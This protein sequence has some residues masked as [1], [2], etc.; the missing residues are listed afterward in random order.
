MTDLIFSIWRNSK[1]WDCVDNFTQGQ[2]KTGT[3]QNTFK[4]TMGGKKILMIITPVILWSQ[5]LNGEGLCRCLGYSPALVP[6]SSWYQP[7][8]IWR[9]NPRSQSSNFKSIQ[10]LSCLVYTPW[11]SGRWVSNL[12]D[13]YSVKSLLQSNSYPE[14]KVRTAVS[15]I[16]QEKKRNVLFLLQVSK[17]W[18]M[19]KRRIL[20]YK[21]NILL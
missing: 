8:D 5:A 19:W 7:P 20:G 21:R 16:E 10:P 4:G 1:S 9:G 11:R 12:I 17:A 3:P 15:K 14:Q 6:V 2:G 13:C 18:T